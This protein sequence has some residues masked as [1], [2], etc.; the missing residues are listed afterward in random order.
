MIVNLNL[1]GIHNAHIQTGPNGM[2]KKSRMHGLAD[3]VV[4]SERKRN[5]GNPATDLGIGQM[6]FDPGRCLNE[7]HGVVLVFFDSGG[8]R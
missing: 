2:V 4:P 1:T 5:V 3:F 6:G 7:I 8:H